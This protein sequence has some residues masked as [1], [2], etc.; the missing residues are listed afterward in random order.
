MEPMLYQDSQPREPIVWPS[1]AWDA[2][3][4]R[5]ATPEGIEGAIAYATVRL[6]GL[7]G[8]MCG[9]TAEDLVHDA[10][11]AT[12]DGVIRWR[13]DRVSLSAHLCD[14]V[15][16]VLKRGRRRAER[17][18]QLDHLAENDEEGQHIER[19]F[20]SCETDTEDA[21]DLR[22]ATRACE[23]ALWTLAVGDAA[24]L[25]YMTAVLGGADDDGEVAASTGLS[26]VEVRAARRR[27][28][29]LV[30]ELPSALRER[31]QSLLS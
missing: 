27:L 28:R 14:R 1:P 13:R 8:V 7:D 24:A 9:D 25:S 10:L 16:V 23:A 6:A 26:R 5:Q 15:K 22:S 17:G 3:Y 11:I 2:E 4:M 29:R 21:I 12:C 20:L 30:E 18:V 19:R 31:T